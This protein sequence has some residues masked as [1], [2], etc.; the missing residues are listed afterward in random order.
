MISA[1]YT[2]RCDNCGESEKH[3]SKEY[4]E[5]I[6]LEHKCDPVL[7]NLVSSIKTEFKRD[8]KIINNNGAIGNVSKYL[9]ISDNL[10]RHILTEMEDRELAKIAI[11]YRI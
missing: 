9:G 5:G 11:P 7:Y 2:W 4:L 1:V 3:L 6:S 10:A 8:G